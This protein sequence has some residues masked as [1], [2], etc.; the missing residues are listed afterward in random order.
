MSD[1]ETEQVEPPCEDVIVETEMPTKK[2]KVK[3]APTAY[4]QFV[5]DT[6]GTLTEVPT[7]ERFKKCSELWKQKKEKDAAEAAKPKKVT[8]KKPPAKKPAKKAKK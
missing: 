3:R 2:Q 1:L 7:K 5:K 6:Y 8:K 4:N